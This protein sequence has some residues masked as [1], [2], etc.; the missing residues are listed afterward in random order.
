MKKLA[1]ISLIVAPAYSAAALEMLD[2]AEL[3]GVTGQAGI[4]V[5]IDAMV[6]IGELSYVDDG[7]PLSLE[8]VKIHNSRDSSLGANSLVNIDVNS[9]GELVVHQ[10]ADETRLQIDEIKVNAAATGPNSFG[11]VAL[12]FDME[13]FVRFAGGGRYNS[14]SGMTVS[15]Y[16]SRI[17]GVERDVNGDLVLDGSGNPIYKGAEFFYRDNG[18]D[19]MVS[20]DYEHWGTDWTLDVVA[21]PYKPGQDAILIT[22]P[23]HNFQLTVDEIKFKTRDT[24]NNV[25]TDDPNNTGLADQ[26][27]IGMLTASGHVDGELYISAGGKDPEQGLTFNYD[28]T[29]TAGDF[30]YIDTNS[31]GQQYEVALVGVTHDTQ[32][33]NLTFDV[34]NDGLWIATE[35]A[36]GSLSVSDIYLGTDYSLADS[37]KTSMGSLHIDYLYEDQTI[38]STT[39][40]N[41]A[42]LS[43]KGNQYGGDQGITI[44]SQWSLSNADIGYTDDG[45]TVW[46]SGI[47]SYGSGNITFDL[48]DA[49]YLYANNTVDAGA[50]PFFDGIRIGYENVVGHYSIDGIKVGSDKNSAELQGGTELLLPLNVFQEADFTLNGHMTL[51]PGGED[52]DGLT[53]NS[54]LHF[55]DTTFGLTVD[56]DRSGIWLDDVTYDISMRDATLDV[57]DRGVVLNRGLYVSN[58]DVGSVRFGDKSTGDSLGRV[59]I[60]R[61]EK[62]SSMYLRSGGAGAICIGGTSGSEAGCVADGG[63]WEDRGDQGVTIGIT[64]HF[65]QKGSLSAEDQALVNAID[66]NA[67]TKLGWYREDGK[68]GIEAVGISTGAD[69]LTVELAVD[70][71]DTVVKDKVTGVESIKTGFAVD[72][73]VQFSRLNIDRINMNHHVGG[74]QPIF[75][76][77]QFENVNLRAN[78]TATPIQ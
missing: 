31:A 28:Q 52:G 23:D 46:L 5:E 51:L 40:T 74:S 8:G 38:G 17:F 58:M 44:A 16:N 20:F 10:F 67:E 27:S 59:V 18:N 6:N 41:E 48:I 45:N 55:T 62:D 43:P 19:L 14:D 25:F 35:R 47:Q 63:R 29:L 73:N 57:D 24:A 54:D 72:T 64:S 13:N 70:V 32:V 30:R 42:R 1:F 3:S 34:L 75:Y 2:E 4:T 71:A 66:P 65:V 60:S 78:I 15:T 22:Y 11:R 26:A 61:L 69:G 53:I 36:Q 56:Q 9:D 68:V 12:D 33:T 76:G 37:A 21:D 39:Y 50:D 77:A 7:N 49:S